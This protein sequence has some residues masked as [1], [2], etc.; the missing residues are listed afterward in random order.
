[1]A[2]V[3]ATMRMESAVRVEDDGNE[4]GATHGTPN[5]G[6]TRLVNEKFRHRFL[7][8]E[9]GGGP[10]TNFEEH[11]EFSLN[12]GAWTTPAGNQAVSYTTSGF[13]LDGDDTTQRLGAGSFLGTNGGMTEDNTVGE[14]NIPDFAGN[15]ECEFE[16]ALVIQRANVTD[17]DTIRLRLVNSANPLDEYNAAS[18]FDITVDKPANPRRV[19]LLG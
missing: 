8:Q 1:M 14:S 18:L 12:G 5:A 17:G 2:H 7:V 13:Y 6:Y 4:A 9:V 11:I 15:D 3:T 16:F 19:V 10:S